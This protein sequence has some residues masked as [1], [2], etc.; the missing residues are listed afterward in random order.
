MMTDASTQSFAPGAGACSDQYGATRKTERCRCSVRQ[1][2]NDCLTA[3]V[4]VEVAHGVTHRA[5]HRQTAKDAF[6]VTEAVDDNRL[7]GR[8]PSRGAD[9]R[10]DRGRDAGD[11]P[12]TAGN[13]LDVHAWIGQCTRHSC[14]L[15]LVLHRGSGTGDC[16]LSLVIIAFQNA[17][18]L[19]LLLAIEPVIR[20]QTRTPAFDDQSFGHELGNARLDLEILALGP[21]LQQPPLR[22]AVQRVL[23]VRMNL[24]VMKDVACDLTFLLRQNAHSLHLS[25]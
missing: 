7:F 10:G 8:T 13:F 12:N 23:R 16:N 18:Y 17:S 19:F 20:R 2:D 4:Q 6:I 25:Y 14:Y 11:G 21:F 24:K 22:D 9:K 5:V 3:A 15:L 1:S